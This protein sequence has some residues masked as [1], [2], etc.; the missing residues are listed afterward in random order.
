MGPPWS[1]CAAQPLQ[2]RSQRAWLCSNVILVTYTFGAAQVAPASG[3]AERSVWLR[4]GAVTE[5]CAC[6]PQAVHVSLCLLLCMRGSLPVCRLHQPHSTL[7]Q[8]RALSQCR[9]ILRVQAFSAGSQQHTRGCPVVTCGGTVRQH[10]GA[11][12]SA[13]TCSLGRWGGRGKSC[14]RQRAAWRCMRPARCSHAAWEAAGGR[15]VRTLLA[16]IWSELL[17]HQQACCCCSSAAGC[18][19]TAP[20]AVIVLEIFSGSGREPSESKGMGA[21]VCTLQLLS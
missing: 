17:P 6:K 13:A 12:C 14:G 2:Q 21:W 19:I 3:P 4:S 11:E 15:Q 10:S 18:C 5:W 16:G 7:C 9:L 20:S 8:G 1:F